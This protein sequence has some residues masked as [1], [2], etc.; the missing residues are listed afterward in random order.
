MLRSIL[1]MV[2]GF[3][4]LNAVVIAGG[5]TLQMLGRLPTNAAEIT[6]T[7]LF[8]S[9]VFNFLG[10]FFAGGLCGMVAQRAPI[11]HAAALAGTVFF[12][13]IGDTHRFW[14]APSPDAPPHWYLL[15]LLFGAP[16]FIVLGG[17]WQQRRASRVGA[18]AAPMHRP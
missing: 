13:S 3:L 12:V 17:F 7:Y 8:W 4:A 9:L 16:L 6:A 5:V 10:A 18:S 1:S 11:A 2:V 15:C 14:T